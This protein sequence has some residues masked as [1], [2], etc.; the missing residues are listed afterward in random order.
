MSLNETLDTTSK[1]CT[2]YDIKYYSETSG[3]SNY[4]VINQIVLCVFN[5]VLILS[6]ISLNSVAI[7]TISKSSQLK[8]KL[9]Y[10]VVLL[11]SITDLIV[12][13]VV[14][15]LFILVL[16]SEIKGKLIN[17]VS[18]RNTKDT[19]VGGKVT[20]TLKEILSDL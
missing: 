9:C 1:I 4:F 20:T 13:V 10:F 19:Y 11:Q 3:T 8:E 16:A 6:T 2:F 7:R 5:G 17:T 18:N 12:G 14:L 15:P